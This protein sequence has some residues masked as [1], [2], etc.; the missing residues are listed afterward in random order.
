LTSVLGWSNKELDLLKPFFN[1]NIYHKRNIMKK[2]EKSN[3]EFTI[4]VKDFTTN[5]DVVDY[6]IE[7][8]NTSLELNIDEDFNMR[9]KQV[10]EFELS[11]KKN[12]L[13]IKI[14]DCGCGQ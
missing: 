4:E 7:A 5:K 3:L 2:T 14:Q 10:D 13:K 11:L 9:M 6:L 1:Y 12:N 8:I